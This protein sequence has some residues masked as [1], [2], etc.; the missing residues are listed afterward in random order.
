MNL[1]LEF[2]LTFE[3]YREAQR[4]HFFAAIKPRSKSKWRF[5]AAF[6]VIFVTIFVTLQ[7]RKTA[8]PA[9]EQTT[10]EQGTEAGGNSLKSLWVPLLPYLGYLLVFIVTVIVLLRILIRRNWRNERLIKGVLRLDLSD[11]KFRIASKLTTTELVWAA[12]IRWEE[13]VHLFVLYMSENRIEIVPK[14]P[15]ATSDDL[16]AFRR[17]LSNTVT[18]CAVK[19][20]SAGV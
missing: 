15:F 19:T 8:E 6:A 1:H 5:F 16:D 3:E 20:D 9:P 7:N 17:F 18:R 2:E 11:E 12:F 10:Q 13:T 4:A 14:R